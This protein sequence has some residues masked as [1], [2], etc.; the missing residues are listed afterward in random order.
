MKKVF[1]F[2]L[3]ILAC[4]SLCSQGFALE[5]LGHTRSGIEGESERAYIR[6][7]LVVRGIVTE[8]MSLHKGWWT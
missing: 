5:L 8:H 1:T 2:F 7:C 3:T 6:T 4:I